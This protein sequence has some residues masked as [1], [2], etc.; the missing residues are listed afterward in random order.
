MVNPDL[1][2]YVKQNMNSFTQEQITQTLMS[3]GYTIEEV[4]EAFELSNL[5]NQSMIKPG[6]V[7]S[8]INNTENPQNLNNASYKN[9]TEEIQPNNQNNY[10][11][12]N[13]KETENNNEYSEN[14]NN[15]NELKLIFIILPITF[16]L[17]VGIVAGIYLLNDGTSNNIPQQNPTFTES[18]NSG[19]IVTNTPGIQDSNNEIDEST[20]NQEED[21]SN[22]C[23]INVFGRE[24]ELSIGQ[25]RGLISSGYNGEVTEVQWNIENEEIG[26]IMPR[27]G[28]ASSVTGLKEGE[29]RI[30]V[31]DTS[32][33]ED[34]TYGIR[35]IV[36]E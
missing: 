8:Q 32:V 35:V 36:S 15:K 9:Q 18:Q 14:T 23:R 33:G 29:T 2:E 11:Y 22:E 4:N 13:I 5:A 31:T 3:S 1:V 7:Q 30:I 25:A 34:C 17:F 21:D 24:V 12:N 28:S 16:V 6:E 19:N 26:R 27:I 10:K 20:F